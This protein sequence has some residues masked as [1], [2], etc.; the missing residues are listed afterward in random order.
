MKSIPYAYAIGSIMYAML[1]PRPD[2]AYSISVM[3]RYQQ[4]PGEAHWVA[5]KNILKYLRRTKDLFLVFGGSEDEISV[6][7]YTD[8]SFQ[9]D[10]DDFRSKS[11]YVFDHDQ[12]QELKE[13]VLKTTD[14][15]HQAKT[16]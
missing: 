6:T 15:D 11:G 1:C 4:N 9:T 5:V 13:S 7:E 16:S 12:D 14:P 3:S 10:R 2:V 8:A